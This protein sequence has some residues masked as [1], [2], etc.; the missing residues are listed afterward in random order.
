MSYE[1]NGIPEFQSVI[2]PIH[3]SFVGSVNCSHMLY[4]QPKCPIFCLSFKSGPGVIYDRM[5]CATMETEQGCEKDQ[6]NTRS[7]KIPSK[8]TGIQVKLNVGEISDHGPNKGT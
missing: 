7:D 3:H 5:V 8:G 1:L 2:L 6:V 4:M